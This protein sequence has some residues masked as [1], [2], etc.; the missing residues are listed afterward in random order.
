[1]IIPPFSSPISI[2]NK[3]RPTDMAS[4][5]ELGIE[6]LMILEYFVK[7]MI[8]KI[9]PEINTAPRADCHDRPIP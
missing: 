3:P 9:T 4:F 8:T 5:I 1:V 2:K 7:A 6:S